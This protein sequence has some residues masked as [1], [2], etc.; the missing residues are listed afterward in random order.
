MNNSNDP[1]FALNFIVFVGLISILYFVY[2][3]LYK[4]PGEKKPD[5]KPRFDWYVEQYYFSKDPLGTERGY[6]EK[7]QY[8]ETF[9]QLAT[10]RTHNIV[11][12]FGWGASVQFEVALND[13]I[14]VFTNY[15]NPFY[16]DKSGHY[17]NLVNSIYLSGNVDG[18]QVA[19]EILLRASTIGCVSLITVL[20]MIDDRKDRKSLH[21]WKNRI[22]V[23][24]NGS[25]NSELVCEWCT[26]GSKVSKVECPECGFK[27]ST[28]SLKGLMKH[29]NNNHASNEFPKDS[30]CEKHSKYR[31]VEPR[32]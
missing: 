28:D 24:M 14:M 8:S 5:N 13:F 30:C 18:P 2:H 32:L 1:A 26:I 21:Q 16:N 20:S 23:A 29:W 9:D 4:V 7:K 27:S 3:R 31:M 25:S 15:N 17:A 19:E 10:R 11:D 6:Y 12:S 22:K